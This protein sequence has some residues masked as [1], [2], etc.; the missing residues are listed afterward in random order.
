MIMRILA[1]SDIR[2]KR[3]EGR[4]IGYWL[5]GMELGWVG[6][7]VVAQRRVKQTEQT[8]GVKISSTE[9]RKRRFEILA[10]RAKGCSASSR[11]RTYPS[12]RNGRIHC[13]NPRTEGSDVRAGM[14][15]WFD[16]VTF[17]SCRRN[18][19]LRAA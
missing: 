18:R 13:P 4:G 14:V 2:G 7:G 11:S 3:T 12:R 15:F 8:E 17:D 19:K 1:V 5:Q 6:Y 10:F 16:A 9:E